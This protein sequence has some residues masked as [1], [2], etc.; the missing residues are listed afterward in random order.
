MFLVRVSHQVNVLHYVVVK[1]RKPEVNTFI[2][3]YLSEVSL[4][5]LMG[6]MRLNIG[7]KRKIS[8]FSKGMK[9][10]FYNLINKHIHGHRLVFSFFLFDNLY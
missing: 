5:H 3:E 7:Q 10:F 2:W 4:D 6:A 8:F 9:V 1:K